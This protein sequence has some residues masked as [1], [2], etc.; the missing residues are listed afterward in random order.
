M[1]L[2]LI[3]DDSTISRELLLRWRPRGWVVQACFSLG[4][5]DQVLALSPDSGAFDLI[6]LDL[7]LPDGDGGHWL[8]KLRQRDRQTPVLVLTARDSVADRVLGLRCGADDYLVKPFA[9]DELDARVEALRRRSQVSSGGLLHYGCLTW[10]G[11]EGR[12]YIEERALELSPREFEVLG[13][14]IRR[15][16]RLVSKRALLDALA[17]RNLEIGDNVAELYVSRL[18]RKLAGSGT[19]IRTLRGFGYLLALDADA[20][21]H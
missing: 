8:T 6:V 12:A 10:L 2:L 14:L 21:S 4:A 1:R 13:I 5:A 9:A 20:G 19:V 15:A 16:P 3:E 7:G 18:R 17:D 11:D